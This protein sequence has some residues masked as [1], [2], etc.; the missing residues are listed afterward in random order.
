M[1][2]KEVFRIDGNG[3]HVRV[4]SLQRNFSI[5]EK[6][7]TGR[8]QDGQMFRD[9]FGTYYHYTM[10][11]APKNG[12]RAAL[13]AFWEAISQPDISHICE[14][15][16]GQRT[17]TQRMYVTAGQQELKRMGDEGNTWGELTIHFLAVKPEVKP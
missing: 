14:F 10:K 8:T 15:P 12:D 1:T 16:Y 3:Y 4:L 7:K 5:E 17:L 6:G 9:V 2:E 13:D 11:I